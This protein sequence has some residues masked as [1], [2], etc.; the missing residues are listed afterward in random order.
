MKTSSW[1]S[2]AGRVLATLLIAAVGWAV[3]GYL[4]T[5]PLGALYGWSG[6]PALP[7]A[8][9]AVYI[10]LYLVALP[11]ACLVGARWLVYGTRG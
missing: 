1:V 2:E 10:G 4:A 7:A 9:P 5:V 8:P 6:H 11:V 3:I